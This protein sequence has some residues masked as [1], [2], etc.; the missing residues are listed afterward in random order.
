MESREHVDGRQWY[1]AIRSVITPNEHLYQWP[2][3]DTESS[4]H[5]I[6]NHPTTSFTPINPNRPQFQTSNPL[7]RGLEGDTLFDLHEELVS[8]I[9]TQIAKKR[10]TTHTKGRVVSSGQVQ[11]HGD[12]RDQVDG[13]NEGP[14]QVS[15]PKRKKATPTQRSQSLQAPPMP[16]PKVWKQV[17][18]DTT[19][20]DRENP[21]GQA[22]QLSA[23]F[24]PPDSGKRK[25]S[26]AGSLIQ[27]NKGK[28]KEL[29][30]DSAIIK[31]SISQRKDLTQET[32][33]SKYMINH[34]GWTTTEEN[35]KSSPASVVLAKTTLEKLAAFRYRPAS[36]HQTANSSYPVLENMTDE[37]RTGMLPH[38][39]LQHEAD[40]HK[41]DYD[42]LPSSDYFSAEAL[43]GLQVNT[44]HAHSDVFTE[45]AMT[46]NPIHDGSTRSLDVPQPE[47]E[48]GCDRL[49]ERKEQESGVLSH[50]CSTSTKNLPQSQV[51]AMESYGYFDDYYEPK[52]S[53]REVFNDLLSGV[54]VV[55]GDATQ[56][57]SDYDEPTSSEAMIANHQLHQVGDIETAHHIVVEEFQSRQDG[58]LKVQSLEH[59]SHDNHGRFEYSDNPSRAGSSR[60]LDTNKIDG[61]VVPAEIHGKHITPISLINDFQVLSKK[62]ESHIADPS[63]KSVGREYSTEVQVERS[64]MDDFEMISKEAS[65]DSLGSDEFDEGLDDNELLAIVSEVVAPQTSMKLHQQSACGDYALS[66]PRPA[67]AGLDSENFSLKT[68]GPLI[69]Q[70]PTEQVVVDLAFPP[71]GVRFSEFD[72]EFPIDDGDEEE[73]VKLSELGVGIRERFSV[74]ESVQQAF[75]ELNDGEVYDS[76]LQFSSPRP[77]ASGASPYKAIAGR[78][79]DKNKAPRNAKNPVPLREEEDWSFISS[80]EV[81]EHAGV[82]TPQAVVRLTKPRPALPSTPCRRS[83][84]DDSMVRTPATDMTSDSA[85]SV[86]DDNHEYKPMKPFARPDFPALVLDRS[87][88]VGFSGQSYLRTCFRIGEMFKEGAR[89]SSLGQD[90][91]IELFARVTLSSRETGS[92]KQHFHFADLWHDRRPYPNGILANYKTSGLVESESKVFLS[93]NGKMARCLGRLKRDF[94]IGVWMLHIINIRETDWE[95]I[96]W[97]KEIVSHGQVK[98]DK[99][100]QWANL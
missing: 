36:G 85:W 28:Q 25:K 88:V 33:S 77:Q 82:Q 17:R 43:W 45:P 78:H 81:V 8:E 98:T 74:P 1:K 64:N 54:Y 18:D 48:I 90:A 44:N 51:H 41:S 61:H 55:S 71:P 7:R 70:H 4:N 39:P 86:L 65:K 67:A 37:P 63:S 75:D 16:L 46:W 52:S 40:H 29:F 31:P 24:T 91:V 83:A 11:E 73:M 72:D 93:G 32:P 89:C 60:E 47:L 15:S 62:T 26:R 34:R 69:S 30:H 50:G 35:L 76:S 87:P 2:L 92:T 21:L 6:A 23:Q 5:I 100:W 68:R 9:S 12:D 20:Q 42:L 59:D 13:T 3:T 66:L 84:A 57:V 38:Q 94:K 97:T 95:E 96:R 19:I 14:F 58:P 49:G 99:G 27:Q 10:K 56:H 79:T 53:E 22:S 80:G